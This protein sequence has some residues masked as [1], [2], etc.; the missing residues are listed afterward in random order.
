MALV[1][2]VIET[3]GLPL[4]VGAWSQAIFLLLALPPTIIVA[5]LSQKWIEQRLCGWLRALVRNQPR[6]VNLPT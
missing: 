5:W 1:K 4:M 2:R 3:T 6:T